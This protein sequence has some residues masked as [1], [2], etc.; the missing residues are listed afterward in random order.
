MVLQAVVIAAAKTRRIANAGEG[1]ERCVRLMRLVSLRTAFHHSAAMP[2][3]SNKLGKPW[4]PC[5]PLSRVIGRL[6]KVSAISGRFW[7]ERAAAALAAAAMET[8]MRGFD[9]TARQVI[10]FPRQ[11]K[12]ARPVAGRGSKPN[13]AD[14][15]TVSDDDRVSSAFVDV[16]R[17]ITDLARRLKCL[18]YFDDDNDWPRA[19]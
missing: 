10:P 12:A 14:R 9:R 2:D 6:T 18:G 1:F 17:R 4:R 5:G 11:P 16:S 13:S 19:A 8:S 15:S 7:M 3:S